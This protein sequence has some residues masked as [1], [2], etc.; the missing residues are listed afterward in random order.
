MPPISGRVVLFT[1]GALVASLS[2]SGCA[3]APPKSAQAPIA[4]E[5]PVDDAAVAAAEQY[6]QQVAAAL[7]PQQPTI[8]SP[9]EVQWLEPGSSVPTAP[10][11]PQ[12][13]PA[14]PVTFEDEPAPLMVEEAPPEPEPVVEAS[15]M[16]EPAPLLPVADRRALR[17]QLV[18]AIAASNA[19]PLQKALDAATLGLLDPVTTPP[20][21]ILGALSFEQR[22]NVE[23][24]HQV[25]SMLLT[26]LAKGSELDRDTF[27]ARLDE[28][29][30]HQPISISRV[31]LC[32][33]VQGY[34]IYEPFDG[35]S[36]LAGRDQK[37]IVYT[38]LDHFLTKEADN[39]QYEVKLEQEVA[40]FNETDGLAVWK[41]DPV[42]IVDLSRNKRRDFFVVQLITLPARLSVGRY[43]LKVRIT[44]MHGGSIDEV[45]TP[46]EIVADQ[47][48]VQADANNRRQR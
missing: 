36:F 8:D 15:P 22:D 30:G 45:T 12:A 44:D 41:N 3:T 7:G 33:R 31:Q 25:M 27:Q 19:T 4:P 6:A 32:R 34:G 9:P 10:L 5:E 38:E 29:F 23:R 47:S 48:L 39:G 17:E 2:L 42:Q 11:R 14:R 18:S 28:L 46:V 35:T 13:A 1:T 16:P 20:E 40:L 24:Y 21:A 26:E 37:M 43:R